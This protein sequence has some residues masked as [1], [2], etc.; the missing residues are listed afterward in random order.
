MLV[1]IIWRVLGWIIISWEWK[2]MCMSVCDSSCDNN[3]TTVPL[4]AVLWWVN[5]SHK[6]CTLYMNLKCIAMCVHV[7]AHYSGCGGGFEIKASTSKLS[8]ANNAC[9]TIIHVRSQVASFK[10]RKWREKRTEKISLPP[11][12]T[13]EIITLLRIVVILFQ[14]FELFRAASNFET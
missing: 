10:T 9:Y 13:F 14:N 3:V 11:S 2:K 5:T 12:S 7:W 6:S 8:S 4:V 1:I